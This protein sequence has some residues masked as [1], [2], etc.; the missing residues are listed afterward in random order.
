MIAVI[1]LIKRVES[2]VYWKIY[3]QIDFNLCTKCAQF[4][5]K[6]KLIYAQK[7]Q[8]LPKPVQKGFL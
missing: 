7:I 3:V 2:V 6:M 4:M 8:H 1:F 5:H